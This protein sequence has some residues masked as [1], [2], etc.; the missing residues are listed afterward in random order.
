MRTLFN[1]S[2]SASFLMPA[3]A[4]TKR[5]SMRSA[6]RNSVLTGLVLG[7]ATFSS[8]QA[9]DM[10]EVK[11][12]KEG[13][14]S[15]RLARIDTFMNQAVA[16]G[17]MVGGLGMIA[18]NGNVVYSSTWG[19]RD[20]EQELPMTDDTLFRI[21]SMTKP[22]TGV[23]L[24]M[25]FEEGKFLLN[26]PV[27]KYIPELANLTVA[28]ST[29]DGQVRG[30]SNGTQSSTQG[31]GDASKVGMTRAPARQPTIRDLMRHT[32][33]FTYGV[34]GNT[35]VDQQYREAGLLRD[36]PNLQD[37]VAKLG[38]I[39]LQYEPGTRWHY[40]VSVDVQGRLVEVLSG[41]KFSEFLQQRIFA[42]LGM[43][44]TSFTVP[45]AKQ[46]RLAQLYAPKGTPGSV[47]AWLTPNTSAEL[48]V[49]NDYANQGYMPGATFES[50][51][52]GLVSST[53][54]YLRFSQMMLN[55]GELDGVRLLGPKTVEL[56][57]RNHLG[58]IPMGFGGVGSGFGLDF[59][60]LLDPGAAGE[61]GSEGEY[62]WGG[63][64]GT[65]F[66]IDPKENVI[67]LFM[68]Q[69]LPHRTTLGAKFKSLTYQA[70]VK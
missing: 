33:G 27:A 24:M 46:P 22:I 56:M 57:S 40:S 67:G 62:S 44:D 18:R 25:L 6:L 59:G 65:K 60:V 28:V 41:M 20:R 66:W 8:A 13:F 23:A 53:M 15:E 17:V 9:R 4:K 31:V 26:E 39:P 55:G 47:N 3:I 34:F 43:T 38:K 51:G 45:V 5:F 29:A 36:H 32:A 2:S 19:Q 16:D 35:E 42:P 7:I 37:F 68:V 48:E 52:G 61:P 14:S 30:Q 63:A 69:S 21:Y 64:A 49:A 10:R 54:D 50:G 12:A 58:E 11:P 1:P 70:L